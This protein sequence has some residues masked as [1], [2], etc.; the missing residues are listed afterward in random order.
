[1]NDNHLPPPP[2][3]PVGLF[4]SF[5]SPLSVMNTIR[6]GSLSAQSNTVSCG[7]T[8]GGNDSNW[9]KIFD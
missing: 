3:S 8:K 6:L 9:A 1:M 2:P 7:W 4:K 5:T